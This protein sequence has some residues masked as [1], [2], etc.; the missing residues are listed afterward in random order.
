MFIGKNM[1][2]LI[3]SVLAIITLASVS[4]SQEYQLSEYER[5]ILEF[6]K[7]EKFRYRAEELIDRINN[8]DKYKI[9]EIVTFPSLQS[10]S[11]EQIVSFSNI[12]ESEVHAAINPTNPNNIVVSPINQNTTNPLSAITCPIYYSNDQGKTWQKSNFVTNQ[13][14]II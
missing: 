11:S 13:T 4:F 1:K 2:T 9:D 6:W 10:E 7:K 14:S 3:I 12:V 5:G 8:P